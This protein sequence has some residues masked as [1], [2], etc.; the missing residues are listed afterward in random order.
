[1]SA[2]PPKADIAKRDRH[3]R[4]AP[5]ADIK[6]LACMIDLGPKKVLEFAGQHHETSP[7]QI[8]AS[9]RRCCRVSFFAAL[10]IGVRLSNVRYI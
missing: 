4:F 3:V 2:L 10:R 1:M 5:I 8:F 7:P 6:A 9:G